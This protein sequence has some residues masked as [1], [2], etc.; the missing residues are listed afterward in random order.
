MSYLVVV[1]VCKRIGDLYP[2]RV[3]WSCKGQIRGASLCDVAVVVQ[4]CAV[5]S[6]KSIGSEPLDR[7][8]WLVRSVSFV[9]SAGCSSTSCRIGGVNFS[10]S[11]S[12]VGVVVRA[13]IDSVDTEMVVVVVGSLDRSGCFFAIL[14]TL[15]SLVGAFFL[16]LGA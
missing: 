7:L 13:V 1:S 4:L 14:V 12:S 8:C 9:G 10:P 3:H 5:L 15:V 2:W 11:V 6:E 16:M